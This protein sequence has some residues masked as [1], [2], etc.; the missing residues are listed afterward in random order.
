MNSITIFGSSH[1]SHA[2]GDSDVATCATINHSVSPAANTGSIYATR[3]GDGSSIDSDVATDAIKVGTDA[4]SVCATRSFDNATFYDDVATY[5]III[6][7]SADARTSISTLSSQR[8][9]ALNGECLA[10][11]SNPEGWISF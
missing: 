9:F 7:S 2:V 5:F 6:I 4:C 1:A 11:V 10:G 8:A 3:S